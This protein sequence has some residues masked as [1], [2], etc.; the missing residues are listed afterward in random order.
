MVQDVVEEE[1]KM[2]I[3]IRKGNLASFQNYYGEYDY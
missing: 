1:G 3:F 2:F